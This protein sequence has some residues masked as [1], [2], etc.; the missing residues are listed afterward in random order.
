MGIGLPY[1]Y[2][3]KV[4]ELEREATRGEAAMLIVEAL[5]TIN[6]N[7]GYVKGTEYLKDFKD[8][9]SIDAIEEK[10]IVGSANTLVKLGILEGFPDGTLGLE[11][12]LTRAQVSKLVYIALHDYTNWW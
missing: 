3:M 1:I 2:Y 5:W 6:Y 9:D 11:K 8:A 12:N 4:E 7:F 10:R